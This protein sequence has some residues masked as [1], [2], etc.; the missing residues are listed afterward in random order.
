MSENKNKRVCGCGWPFPEV[1][2]LSES[3][4]IPPLPSIMIRC[5]RCDRTYAKDPGPFR[6][7]RLEVELIDQRA[8][9]DE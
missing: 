7:E 9:Y 1:G 4:L 8:E 6:P 2:L 3:P 5:P